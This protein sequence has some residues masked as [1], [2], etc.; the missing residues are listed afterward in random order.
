MSSAGDSSLKTRVLFVIPN[1]RFGGAERQVVLLLRGLDRSRYSVALCCCNLE[2]DFLEEVPEAVALYDL[3]KKSRWSFLRIVLRLRQALNDFCPEVIVATLEYGALISYL[4]NRFRSRRVPL[5]VNQQI[6]TSESRWRETFSSAKKFIDKKV[7]R[8]ADM[9]VAPSEGILKELRTDLS[10]YGVRLAKIPNA[11]DFER[12][13]PLLDSKTQ[14]VRI[15]GMGRFVAWK[16]FELLIRAFST[17]PRGS[18]ELHLLGDGPERRGLETLAKDLGIGGSVHFH[19]F[20]HDPFV[21]LR[22][23]SIG[24]VPSEFEAFGNVIIEMFAAGMPVVAFDVN[25]GPRELISD[26]VNGILLSTRNAK[27]L[28]EA[29]T[30]LVKDLPRTKQLGLQARQEAERKYG[31]VRAV[32]QY[33]GCFELLLGRP[34]NPARIA[35]YLRPI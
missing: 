30:G 20:L 15:V 1:L 9:V 18:A 8:R 33:E 35:G 6:M 26:G 22:E 12:I 32:E 2:G 10:Q 7:M 5:I 27:T 31:I 3:D 29:I 11:V 25:Y 34:M 19:G 16:G 4:A 14:R 28:G 13:P 21:V 17:V 24:V 23:A